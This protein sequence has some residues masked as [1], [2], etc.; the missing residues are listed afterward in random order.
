MVEAEPK[1]VVERYL[2]EVLNGT[3]PGSAAELI[4]NEAFED[5]VQGF[6]GAFPDLSVETRL[7]SWR[8][9]SSGFTPWG[10]GR[11]R[12]SSTGIRQ[13]AGA[14]RRPAQ[15]S[16]ESTMA[17]SRMPGSTGTCSRSWSSSDA[18]SVPRP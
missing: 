12:D 18:S 6:R 8:A 2:A 3:N 17:A 13:R 5:R 16:T 14:G 4:S 15:R 11:T 10:E 7:C 9:A 1:R